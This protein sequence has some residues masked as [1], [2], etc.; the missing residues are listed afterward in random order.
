ML[1]EKRTFISPHQ[2]NAHLS[3]VPTSHGAEVSRL[4]AGRQIPERPLTVQPRTLSNPFH[5]VHHELAKHR[6]Y[7]RLH[8]RN[9]YHSYS[10]E[11]RPKQH[12]V[13]IDINWSRHHDDQQ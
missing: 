2:M 13:E 11:P 5:R 12:E 8:P 7:D 4:S 9:M 6:I 1:P 10:P 3:E